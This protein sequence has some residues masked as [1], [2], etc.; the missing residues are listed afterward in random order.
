MSNYYPNRD[1]L[2]S[3]FP[4]N[5]TLVKR[6]MWVRI[7]RGGSIAPTYKTVTGNSVSFTTVRSAP[8]RQLSV[9]FSP[10]QEGSGD[11]SPDNVRPISGWDSL[12]VE[13]RGVNQWDEEWENG[14]W[15]RTTGAKY[16]SDSAYL[17]CADY[18]PC[19]PNTGY[20][21]KSPAVHASSANYAAVMFYDSNKGYISY[22][23]V[24]Q[25]PTF[26]TPA[27]AAF[28]TF[29]VEI[30]TSGSTYN[31]DISINYPATDHDYHAYN[32]AS[33]SISITLGSTVYGGTVDVLTGV[34]KARP[35]YAS[36]NGET[37]VGPWMSS[38]DKY[39]AGATPTV[40]AQVVDMGGA[41]TTIQLTPQEV[42][43]LLGDNVM[44]SDSNGDLTVT[45]RSN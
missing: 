41:E 18:I 37:L 2:W 6:L 22:S 9:A 11:P 26:T 10:V 25:T 7:M 15:S 12:T 40:G 24:A 38:M 31:H 30:G 27:N 5:W 14:Y 21:F 33:R 1:M 44:F 28:M 13:Q 4:T 42:E 45:Y 17:R 34:V 19:L 39:V 32:P 43:S 23:F 36:Y 35:Y 3:G 16:G 29:Y 8:L 20:Y